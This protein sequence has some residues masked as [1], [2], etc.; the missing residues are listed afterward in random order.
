MKIRLLYLE[1]RRFLRGRAPG[2]VSSYLLLLLRPISRFFRPLGARSC[3]ACAS[4]LLRSGCKSLSLAALSS[5]KVVSSKVG[6][7]MWTAVGEVGLLRRFHIVA[8]YCGFTSTPFEASREGSACAESRKGFATA[9]IH[10]TAA[11][12]GGAQCPLII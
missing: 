11:G 7:P 5:S 9:C 2:R 8:D 10:R 12:G 6:L 1:L 4:M 3:C